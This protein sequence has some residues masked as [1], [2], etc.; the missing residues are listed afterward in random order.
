[1]TFNWVQ[2]DVFLCAELIYRAKKYNWRAIYLCGRD[3]G[4]K[5]YI[6]GGGPK[7]SALPCG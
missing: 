4:Q 1:V 7:V 6:G 5:L 2:H 3:V